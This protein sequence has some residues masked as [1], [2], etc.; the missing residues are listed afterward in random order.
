MA[1]TSRRSFLKSGLAAGA[2]A[3]TSN[4]PLFAEPMTA[5]DLVPLGNSGEVSWQG[6]S[7]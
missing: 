2:L 6:Q 1:L 7:F 3:T 4:L 5:T